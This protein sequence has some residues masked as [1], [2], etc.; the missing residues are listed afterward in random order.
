MTLDEAELWDIT[1]KGLV[2]EEAGKLYFIK[3]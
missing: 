1:V 3:T 2:I